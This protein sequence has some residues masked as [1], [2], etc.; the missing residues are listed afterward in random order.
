MPDDPIRTRFAPSPTGALHLG[1]VRTALFNWLYARGRGGRFILRSEDTDAGRSADTSLTALTDALA[2]L[3][4]SVDEGPEEG[5]PC[6][7]YRQSERCRLYGDALA[8]LQEGGHAYRCYCTR[9]ELAAA[10]RRQLA[11][12]RPPRYPGTCRD[13]DAHERGE[14]EAAGRVPTIRF[15][16]P[17]EGSIMFNDLVLG[18]QT[19]R[20]REIGDFIIARSDGSP[21]F[22]LANAVDDAEMAI[23]HVLRGEDHL[24]NTPRQLL[25]LD[26][27]GYERQPRYGH[28]GLILDMDGRPLSKRRG[29]AMLDELRQ[30][31]YRPEALINHLACIGFAPPDP[32]ITELDALAAVFEPARV[33][34]GGARHDATALDGWQRRALD[35]LDP[36]ALWEWMAIGAP[37]DAI[38]LPVAG[39]VFAAAVRPN[40]LFPEDGWRWARRLFDPATEPDSEARTE[41]AAAGPGLFRSALSVQDPAP[42]DDFGA[43][44]KAVGAAAGVKG[45]GLYRPLRA[46]LTN[47]VEGPELGAVVPLIPADLVTARLRACAAD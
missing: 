21:A 40:V 22:F 23:T 9:E 18:P 45:R 35:R 31:G 10:R 12:G 43:W 28:F 13:L 36:D 34:H 3:G 37:D 25:L 7:P 44:A 26:A 38:T 41:I 30:R 24:T 19:A 14:R 47:A 29:G 15:R 17:D 32:G 46:A 16:V 8:R 39:P 6:G 42:T 5:G 11:A 33:A 1:N 4:L 27:L 20:L 2:W